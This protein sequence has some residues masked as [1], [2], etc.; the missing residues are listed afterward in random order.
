MIDPNLG[1]VD[2]CL[3][4]IYVSWAVELWLPFLWFMVMTDM[5]DCE[6]NA[7]VEDWSK[8]RGA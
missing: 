8:F 2:F 4:L 5:K 1:V 3:M 7:W 6:Q